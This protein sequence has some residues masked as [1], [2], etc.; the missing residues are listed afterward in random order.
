MQF[1]PAS[2]HFNP[3]R[4][5]YFPQYP[6]LKHPQCMFLPECENQVSHSYKST[7]KFI[8]LYI[9]IFTFLDCWREGIY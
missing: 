8:V 2:Y 1:S 3:R 4:A 9:L 5:K 6:V 7:G